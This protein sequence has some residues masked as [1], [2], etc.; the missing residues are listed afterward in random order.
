MHYSGC[1]LRILPVPGTD[2]DRLAMQ[3]RAEVMWRCF[4]GCELRTLLVLG[5]RGLVTV[6]QEVV[7]WMCCN[8]CELRTLLVPLVSGMFQMHSKGVMIT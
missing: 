6:L 4:S 3:L 7:I 1:E 5:M 2:P 8:G